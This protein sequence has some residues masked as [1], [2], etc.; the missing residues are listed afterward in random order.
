MAKTR[1]NTGL[2]TVFTYSKNRKVTEKVVEKQSGSDSGG[3][4]EFSERG[5][6]THMW[7]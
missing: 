6:F 4:K 3:E 2:N 1:V 5:K 7:G